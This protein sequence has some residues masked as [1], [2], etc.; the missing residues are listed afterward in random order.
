M[1][2]YNY[3]DYFTRNNNENN[4]I[5]DYGDNPFVINI[6]DITKLN[7]NYRSTLWTGNNTQITLMNI[8]V[9]TDVGLEIHPK[10][11]QI[12]VI[13]QGVGL[14]NMGKEKENVTFSKQ[15]YDG[16]IIVVPQNTWHNIINIGTMPLKLYSIYSPPN[17][18][19]G[20]VHK[21]KA[22]A[23]KEEY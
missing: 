9:G 22:D 15:V 10:V 7:R 1:N 20:T 23:L 8:P 19:K 13:V 17:H 2:Y 4:I 11:D 16:S 5:K 3:Y 14:V 18:K 12:L 6:N 21:T